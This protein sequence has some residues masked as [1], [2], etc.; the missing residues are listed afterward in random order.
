MIVIIDYGVGNVRSVINALLYTGCDVKVSCDPDDIRAGR[1]VILPG[2]GACGY[3]MDALGGLA[4]VICEVAGQGK[5]LLGICLGFQL[6]FDQ[7][8]EHGHTDCLGLISGRVIP[9]PPGRTIPHMGWNLVKWPAEMSLF[10]GL[11]SEGYFAFA[12]SYYA[13]VTDPDAMISRTNY[14][15][16]MCVSVQKKNIFG[17]QFHPEK[18]AAAGLQILRNFEQICKRKTT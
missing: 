18:S 3:A 14:G 4:D 17:C 11:G 12:H 16:D 6:L 9:I 8:S 10:A 1:G 5:P 2:V 15:I 7:S 13:E